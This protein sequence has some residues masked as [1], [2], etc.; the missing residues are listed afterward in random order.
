MSF[1]ATTPHIVGTAI[2]N[3]VWGIESVAF[4]G[5][6]ESITLKRD[7]EESLIFDGNG[8]TIG[9]ILYDD[10]DECTVNM[11]MQTTDTPPDRGDVISVA[12]IVGF[13]VKTREF[14]YNWRDQAKWSF[15][16]TSYVN[17]QTS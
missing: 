10:K 8:F 1:T 3:A 6:C 11:R 5:F 7:G 16:A 9:L 17:V 12:S 13:I 2:T 15:T 14:M 4:A